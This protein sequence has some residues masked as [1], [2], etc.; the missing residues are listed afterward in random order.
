MIGIEPGRRLV[1]EQEIG[2]QHHGAGN[3]GAFLH[4]TRDLARQMVGEWTEPD[5]FELGLA[6]IPHRRAAYRRPGGQGEREV[7]GKRQR[8][9]ERAGL[10]EHTEGRH[11]FVQMRL[12][13][14]VDVDAA[15]LRPLEADQVPQQ[16][17]LA[18]SRSAQDREGRAALDLEAHVLHQDPCPPSDSQIV[19]DDVR[20]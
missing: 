15:G 2:L 1:E 8:T 6:E 3:A 7:L 10:K 4:T 17:A 20:P 9:E 19:D 11:P 12:A 14:A 5:E 16:R 18:A 13:H